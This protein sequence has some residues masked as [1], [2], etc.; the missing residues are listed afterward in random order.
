MV[1]SRPLLPEPWNWHVVVGIF[2]DLYNVKGI[3]RAVLI[4]VIWLE[5]T[6]SFLGKRSSMDAKVIPL[7][8]LQTDTEGYLRRCLDSGESLLVEVPER[9]FV[10]I[11]PVDRNEEVVKGDYNK[12][13][14]PTAQ[15]ESLDTSQVQVDFWRS[16]TLDQLAAAQGVTE[17]CS[18]DGLLGGW[19]EEE[20]DD[21]FEETVA[22]WRKEDVRRSDF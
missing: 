3:E 1:R 21:N 2:T 7:R 22:K 11:Q 14:L 10:T 20:K 6:K 12:A 4:Q 5:R 17:L 13:F 15:P 16:P 19:P 9:G 18:F 8:D